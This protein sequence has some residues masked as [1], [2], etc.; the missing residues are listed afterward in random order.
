LAPLDSLVERELYMKDIADEFSIPIDILQ[1]QLKGYQQEVLKQRPE[2]EP[3]RRTAPHDAAPHALYPSTNKRKV[4]QAEQS[5]KQLLYRL[6]H[7]EEVWSYL[8]EIDADFNFI[9][10]DYQT[11]YIL[12]EE[13]FRQTGL[14]GNIDQFLDRIN[15]PALQN[16][17][18]EIEWFQLDSEVTYQEIQDLVHIIRDKSSLQ[19]QLTKKQAEMKEA[20]KKNDNERLKAIMLDIVSL[21]KE[22]KATKK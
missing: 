7:F 18:T 9:H 20:R 15:N 21:S 16:V 12:Y 14:V 11:I 6:F 17:I 10:D 22:L 8:K 3:V 19:D 5:E 1:K 2:R 13:F 4:T